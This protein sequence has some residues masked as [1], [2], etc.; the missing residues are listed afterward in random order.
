MRIKGERVDRSCK[1]RMAELAVHINT[2]WLSIRF[3]PNSLFKH[4]YGGKLFFKYS[5]YVN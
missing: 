4:Y 1:Y 2:G 3:I 5:Q